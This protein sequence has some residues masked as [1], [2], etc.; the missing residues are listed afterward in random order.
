MVGKN[1]EAGT[2]DSGANAAPALVRSSVGL[3]ASTPAAG[4]PAGAED[5]HQESDA[6]H[7]QHIECRSVGVESEHGDQKHDQKQHTNR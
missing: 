6:R 1:R 5:R 4:R 3:V 7:L 2:P